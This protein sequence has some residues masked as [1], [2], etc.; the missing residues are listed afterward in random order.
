MNPRPHHKHRPLIFFLAL[1]VLASVD[2]SEINLAGKQDLVLRSEVRE[3]VLELAE[4]LLSE[5]SDDFADE[6]A[7][8]D[9]PFVFE[10]IQGAVAE[11]EDQEVEVEP[12]INYDDASVLRLVVESFSRRVSG[13]LVR[14]ETSFLQITG[15]NLIRPGTSFPVTIPQA[16][17]QSFTVTVTKI[18]ENSYTLKLGEAE[19]AV[20]LS[21]TSSA[22]GGAIFTN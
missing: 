9:S 6:V 3:Q 21:G 20:R 10:Q 16:P 18:T 22:D 8:M 1:G 11:V 19:Q 17:G 15:G 14:G 7:E 13:T 4:T 2:A 12:I 5:R